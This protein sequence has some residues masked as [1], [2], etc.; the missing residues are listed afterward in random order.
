MTPLNVIAIAAQQS[1]GRAVFRPAC[2]AGFHAPPCCQNRSGNATVLWRPPCLA[3]GVSQKPSAH[4]R[5]MRSPSSGSS[6]RTLGSF[7]RFRPD[8]IVLT[9]CPARSLTITAPPR[10]GR[11]RVLIGPGVTRPHPPA[12][13][14]IISH[15]LGGIWPHAGP[16]RLGRS[17]LRRR[18]ILPNWVRLTRFVRSSAFRRL[19]RSF[20]WQG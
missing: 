17:L 11:L 7:D 18:T 12:Q 19:I 15:F 10:I 1:H 4:D 16:R 6:R 14:G 13:E 8:G 5:L 9:L 3:P 20:K 2:R